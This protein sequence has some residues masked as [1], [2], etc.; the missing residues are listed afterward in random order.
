[1][2]LPLV[3]RQSLL[4]PQHDMLRFRLLGQGTPCSG[5]VDGAGSGHEEGAPAPTFSS[6]TSSESVEAG[7]SMA[8]R[9]SICR[10]WFCITS[11]VGKR[12]EVGS[13]A[14]RLGV[15]PPWTPPLWPGSGD[16]RAPSYKTCFL[17]LSVCQ[18]PPRKGKR[19]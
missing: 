3:T 10:R 4:V 8:T 19:R 16:F 13:G 1:M 2:G 15:S 7:F 11:L 17:V 9:H 5:L 14:S 12:V 6:R 18:V